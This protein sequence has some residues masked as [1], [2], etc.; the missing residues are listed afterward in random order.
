MLFSTLVVLVYVLTSME[1]GSNS[2]HTESTL[3]YLS[4]WS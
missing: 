1:E 3:Y 4:F 2:A